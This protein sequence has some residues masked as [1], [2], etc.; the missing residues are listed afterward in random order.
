[1]SYRGYGDLVIFYPR[2]WLDI[3]KLQCAVSAQNAVF[4]MRLIL[5]LGSMSSS[6]FIGCGFQRANAQ[7]AVL[8]CLLS[9]LAS[10]R[11]I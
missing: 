10:K 7:N 8:F 1:L 3:G 4:C 5:H 9:F 2:R 6:V 11:C